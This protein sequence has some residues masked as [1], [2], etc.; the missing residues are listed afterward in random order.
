MIFDDIAHTKHKYSEPWQLHVHAR[1]HLLKLRDDHHHQQDHNT[2]SHNHH[3]HRIKHRRL[4]LAFDLLRLFGKF[5][6]TF[7][8]DFQHAAQ[9][10]RL[11]HVD[12]QTV[13]N[14]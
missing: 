7:Q 12:K 6:E 10:A 2:H 4:D 14:L 1:K 11:D 5:R 9:F 3:R 8:Y 13:E